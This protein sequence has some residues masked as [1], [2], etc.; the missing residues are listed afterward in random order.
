M[1]LYNWTSVANQ[2]TMSPAQ[3]QS[4]GLALQEDM[5]THMRKFTA[6]ALVA[7]FGACG[8][9]SAQ[10]SST[11]D[12]YPSGLTLRGGVAIPLDSSLTNVG[13]ALGNIGVEF[14]IRPLLSNGETYVAADWFFRAFGNRG[15]SGNVFP[16]TVNHRVF[17]S[18]N[19]YRSYYFFG[20]GASFISVNGNGTAITGRFGV[21]QE[22]GRAVVAEIAG[23]LSD[24]AGG[25]R[26]NAITFNV[27]YK[28]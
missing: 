28:F 5:R 1:R 15:G 12:L 4:L 3:G 27:G 11:A 16:I 17:T 14:Y 23:L 9:A 22:L 19:E 6:A 2:A 8:I 25:A 26:A 10:S 13:S 21:G 18:D 24:R 20:V 7:A